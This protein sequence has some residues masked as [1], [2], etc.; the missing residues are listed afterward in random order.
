MANQN[1]VILQKD[2]TDTVTERVTAMQSEGLALPKNYDYSN[3]LKSAF[4]TIEKVQDRNK[5]P[6]LKVCDKSSV[7]NSLLNMVIQGLT[8][9]KTQCY[10]VVY[11]TELQLQR[12][13]FGTQAVL[14]R[15]SNVKDIWA[16][17]VHEGD[18][19]EIGSDRGR[20]VVKEFEPK[21]ENQ[22]NPIVG[23]FAVIEKNDGELVYTI[24]TKKEI[25]QSWS[26]TRSGGK[27]QK[28]FPQEMAKRTVINR[29]AKAF[30]NTSDDSDLLTQSIN[31]TTSNEFEEDNKPRK[32][33]EPVKVQRLE[34]K[35][36]MQPK[37][38]PKQTEPV[39]TPEKE[40]EPEQEE[41]FSVPNFGREE[42]AEHSDNSEEDYPF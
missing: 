37:T 29:A 14:K 32:Q 24:M 20:T 30:I 26:K 38:E 39:E 36:N 6:A 1:E 9:A 28:E 25:D 41:L 11:G 42:G 7:A 13:Y 40:V 21:F 15:L 2:I 33:A 4:F 3:A 5:Q 35:M 22:D 12:S 23:T 18:T 10:F 17:V 16:E 19:F 34:E 8:P 31:D 27:V